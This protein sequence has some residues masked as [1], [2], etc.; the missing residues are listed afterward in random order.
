MAVLFREPID[1]LAPAAH[2]GALHLQLHARAPGPLPIHLLRLEDLGLIFG[3]VY[4][5]L[6]VIGGSIRSDL[7]DDLGGLAAG[8]LRIKHRRGDAD[9]L[10]APALA[11]SMKTRAIKQLGKDARNL[12]RH[13][14]RPVILHDDL[15]IIA[16]AFYLHKDVRQY[17][18][19]LAGIQ[20]IVHGLFDAGDQGAGR[21][22]ESQNLTVLLKKFS[23]GDGFLL[24]GQLLSD[25]H[26][27]GKKG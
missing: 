16:A 3:R 2:V 23:Y 26:K 10:L 9:A 21:G 19:I 5:Q 24:L 12:L 6:A 27:I 8:E 17:P 18:C 4:Q 13:N 1:R 7:G 15:I 22:V 11:Q 20:G 25:F 14:A